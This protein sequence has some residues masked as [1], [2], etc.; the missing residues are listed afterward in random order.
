MNKERLLKG[1]I[2]CAETGIEVKK[3][4]CDICTPTCH[5]GLDV[6]VKDGKIIKVEGNQEH[7]TSHGSLCSK[8]SSTRQYVYSPDRIMTPLKRIGPKGS[9]EF[10]PISWEEAYKTIAEKFNALKAAGHPEYASFYVGY[11][12]WMRPYVQ[13]LC[14]TF[15]SPNYSTES[16]TCHKAMYMAWKLVCGSFCIPQ[17]PSTDCLLI[18]SNN[19]F[20]TGTPSVKG[21]LNRLENGMKLI[22]VDP[23]PT[24]AAVRA[25]IHLQVKPGTDGALALAMTHVIISEDLYDKEFVENYT[26][27][28]EEYKEY[29]KD[30]TPE[31]AEE[32]TGVPADLIRKAARMYAGAKSATIMPS[33]SPVV[34][35]T[36]GTQAYRAI[37]M[38]A[39]LTGNFDVPGGN[40]PVK[41]S[42]LNTPGGFPTR[43]AEYME[44]GDL[45][46]M[47]PRIGAD[48]WPVWM[49]LTAEAQSMALPDHVLTEKPYPIKAI[50]AFGM[51]YRMW[52]DS[53]RMKKALE[54]VDF[55]VDID[56]FM[57]DTAKMADIVLPACSSLER[58]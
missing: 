9:G 10:A 30:W 47:A 51:N 46:K 39:G 38:L 49:D 57:T 25:D 29:V 35:H 42:Y 37:F 20:H 55:F 33:A 53:K 8:G 21:L 54:E 23:R 36:N 18:W 7:K 22:V 48:K 3:S 14:R 44:Y 32:I 1:K 56:L 4:I 15:G 2:P 28:F 43:E 40:I 12:K 31:R 16:S 17:V 11:S 26:V 27:G 19:P 50:M 13:R 5:C 6:Y 34:H 58:E 24:P 52:P 41:F 45:D